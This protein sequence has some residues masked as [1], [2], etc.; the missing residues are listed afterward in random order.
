MTKKE[1]W[2]LDWLV[3]DKHMSRYKNLDHATEWINQQGNKIKVINL[4]EL[5]WFLFHDGICVIFKV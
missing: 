5:R 3:F 4:F 1:A 2:G